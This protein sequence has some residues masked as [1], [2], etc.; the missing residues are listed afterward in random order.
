MPPWP[1]IDD[2]GA[3]AMH[4]GGLLGGLVLAMSG[5]VLLVILNSGWFARNAEEAPIIYRP[6]VDPLA[7]E[8]VYCFAIAPALVRQPDRGPVQSRPR[9]RRRRR[10]AC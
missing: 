4:W 5:I 3:R 6:P 9:C 7:R 1:A 2:L 10:C 8:F